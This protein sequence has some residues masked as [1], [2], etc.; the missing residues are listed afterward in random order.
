MSAVTREAEFSLRSRAG[1]VLGP[2][3]LVPARRPSLLAPEPPPLLRL[4][5][6]EGEEVWLGGTELG[7]SSHAVILVCPWTSHPVSEPHTLCCQMGAPSL[8]DNQETQPVQG[9]QS[10]GRP[11]VC[12]PSLSLQAQGL[13]IW[14]REPCCPATV[15]SHYMT[16]PH[17]ETPPHHHS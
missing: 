2:G 6:P 13:Q 15:P 10:R 11:S 8:C 1:Q 9:G 5:H 12:G 14:R 4:L 16:P 3:P 17:Y 7:S